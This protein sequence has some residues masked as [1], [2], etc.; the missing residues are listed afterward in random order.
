M[1]VCH[2]KVVSDRDI[3]AAIAAGAQEVCA[4]ASACGAA[5]DCGGCLPTVRRMLAERGCSVDRRV[6]V[7]A[8]RERTG[9]EVGTPAAAAM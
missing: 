9:R 6:T 7:R 2:C 1:I 5:T 3:D 8:L 4:L